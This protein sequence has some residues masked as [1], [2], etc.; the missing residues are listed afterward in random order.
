MTKKQYVKKVR[1]VQRNIAR[2]AKETG[3]RSIHT[4][5]RVRIPSFGTIIPAG[6]HQ[7]EVLRSYAQCWDMMSHALKG[8][9]LLD[10]V[11]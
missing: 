4:A 6:I 9:D 1:Q 5:D 11:Q 8:T 3:G 10:G 7:G 2:Y